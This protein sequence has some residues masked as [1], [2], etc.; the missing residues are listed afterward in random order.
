MKNGKKSIYL[1]AVFEETENLR[2]SHL[3]DTCSHPQRAPSLAP[4]TIHSHIFVTIISLLKG[5]REC[6]LFLAA[7]SIK[8]ASELPILRSLHTPFSNV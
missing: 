7:L 6:P 8:L 3:Y 2:L 5:K 1:L 4:I